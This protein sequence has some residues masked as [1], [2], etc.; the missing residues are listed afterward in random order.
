MHRRY[1]KDWILRNEKLVNSPAD[2]VKVAQAMLDL[3]IF[4]SVTNSTIFDCKN[5]YAF[6]EPGN[7][8]GLGMLKNRIVAI[9][10]YNIAQTKANKEAQAEAAAKT[11]QLDWRV[12]VTERRLEATEGTLTRALV[13]QQVDF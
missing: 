8:G 1:A 11:V 13:V 10:D 4:H 5:L 3:N 12:S 7:V 6:R 2:A 9:E